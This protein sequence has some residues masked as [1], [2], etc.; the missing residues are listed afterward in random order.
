M[1]KYSNQL[2]ILSTQSMAFEQTLIELTLHFHSLINWHYKW[3]LMINQK[4]AQ[5][6]DQITQLEST[7]IKS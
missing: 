4:F 5:L 2:S 6:N 1:S 3:I 7:K